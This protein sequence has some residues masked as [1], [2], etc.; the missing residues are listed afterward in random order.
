MSFLQNLPG[1]TS[2]FR[3]SN[4]K[5][6][7]WVFIR[8][9]NRSERVHLHFHWWQAKEYFNSRKQYFAPNNMSQPSEKRNKF[10]SDILGN[11]E[12]IW[13]DSEITHHAAGLKK[14]LNQAKISESLKALDERVFGYWFFSKS[15]V[16]LLY[17]HTPWQHWGSYMM[18]V[19]QWSVQEFPSDWHGQ[20]HIV[21]PSRY[22][23]WP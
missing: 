11:Y 6:S 15:V 14:N 2:P 7:K 23:S 17:N 21:P 3:L 12:A 10:A 22:Y 9:A 19:F 4:R 16:N 18:D 1:K 13:A 8:V 5:H 20:E